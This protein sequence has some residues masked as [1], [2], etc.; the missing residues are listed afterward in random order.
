M[1]SDSVKSTQFQD[2]LNSPYLIMLSSIQNIEERVM[3]WTIT[4]FGSKELDK[5]AMIASYVQ[6]DAATRLRLLYSGPTIGQE[7]L[8]SITKKPDTM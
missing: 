2:A 1:S 8:N 3:A 4:A 6:S 5:W 7:F